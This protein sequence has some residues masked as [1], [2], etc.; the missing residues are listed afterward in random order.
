MTSTGEGWPR[1]LAQDWQR[2]HVREG[3]LQIEQPRM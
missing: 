2:W 1:E 3:T